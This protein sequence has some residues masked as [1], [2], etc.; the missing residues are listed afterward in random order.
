VTRQLAAAQAPLYIE[1][2]VAADTAQYNTLGN[3]PLVPTFTFILP[4]PSVIMAFNNIDW[5]T[6][7]TSGEVLSWLEFDGV[8]K[9][10]EELDAIMLNDLRDSIVRVSSTPLGKGPTR[11]AGWRPAPCRTRTR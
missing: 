10:F 7:T 2:Q 8:S 6:N 11:S 4:Q 3:V 9:Q 5:V 1:K